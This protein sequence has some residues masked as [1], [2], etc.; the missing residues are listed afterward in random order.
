MGLSLRHWRPRHLLLAWVAYWLVALA[1]ALGPALASI[2][3]VTSDPDAHGSVNAG[4]T[5]GIFTLSV[6]EPSGVVW[7]GS[8]SLMSIV[9][10]FAVPPLLLFLLWLAARP[11]VPEPALSSPSQR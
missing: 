9:L 7:Q 2:W 3:R 1:V 8:A 5:D 10:W 4:V 6:S 11:R